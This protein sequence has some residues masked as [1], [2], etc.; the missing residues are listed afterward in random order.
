MKKTLVLDPDK[1]I[2]AKEALSHSCLTK[3]ALPDSDCD[4]SSIVTE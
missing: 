1:R 2:T 3:A 4:S